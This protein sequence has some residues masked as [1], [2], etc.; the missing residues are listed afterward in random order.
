MVGGSE[1]S[2]TQEYSLLRVSH[3]IP[4]KGIGRGIVNCIVNTYDHT[5]SGF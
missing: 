3:H 1:P 5:G 4:H 2:A